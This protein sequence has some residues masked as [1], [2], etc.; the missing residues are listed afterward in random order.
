MAKRVTTTIVDDME[1][2]EVRADETVE[3]GLDGDN[4]EI[5][6][7]AR[8]AAKLRGQLGIYVAR[9]RKAEKQ[10]RRRATRTTHEPKDRQHQD[11]AIR[12]WARS[13]AIPVAD[14]GRIPDDVRKRFLEAHAG[15]LPITVPQLQEAE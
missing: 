11:T 4:F 8:N 10:R 7:T 14:R 9:A 3:F 5:D 2:S 12:A 15:P 1:D 6:L 13:Q